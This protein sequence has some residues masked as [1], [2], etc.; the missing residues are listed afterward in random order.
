VPFFSSQ[1]KDPDVKAAHRA[2]ER[3]S[4]LAQLLLSEV[5]TESLGLSPARAQD[6]TRLCRAAYR[7]LR[8]FR[9]GQ[10]E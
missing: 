9:G 2:L 3:L 7:R 8:D 4:D 1:Q 10:G 6:L 5:M